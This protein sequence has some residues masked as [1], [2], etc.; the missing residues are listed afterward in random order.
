MINTRDRRITHKVAKI[1]VEQILDLIAGV[2]FNNVCDLNLS[3]TLSPPR[4]RP[5]FYIFFWFFFGFFPRSLLLKRPTQNQNLP[6]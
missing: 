5:P 1:S 2:Y 6:E 3:K 4:P